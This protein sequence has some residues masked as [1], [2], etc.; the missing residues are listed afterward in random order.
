MRLGYVALTASATTMGYSLLIAVAMMDFTGEEVLT[1]CLAVGP[2][3]LGLGLGSVYGDHIPADKKISRLWLLEWLSVTVLPILPL[4]QLAAVF[5]FLQYTHPSVGLD[6]K[7]GL[8]FCLGIVGV[9]SFIAGILGGAQ[10]PLIL[11]SAQ[12]LSTEVALAFN[13]IGALLAGAGIVFLIALNIPFGHQILI[14][15]IIQLSGL[16]LLLSTFRKRTTGL[17][18]MFIPLIILFGTAHLYP[19]VEHY[20]VKNSYHRTRVDHVSQLFR[21][22]LYQVIKE[23]GELERVRTPYQTIDLFIE[24]PVPHLSIPGN[25]TLYLNRKPQIDILTTAIYH[26]SMVAAALNLFQGMPK[27]ILILGGGDGL[28]L[29]ELKH[30]TSTRITQIELDPLMLQFARDNNVISGLNENILSNM[31]KNM[32]VKIEDAISYLRKNSKEQFDVVIIDLPF[33]NGP[34][35]SRLYSLE[36]YKMVRRV[37]SPGAIVV[38]DLPLYFTEE[39]A[40][41]QESKT[42]LKTLRSAGFRYPLPFGPLASFVAVG[43]NETPLRFDYLRFPEE[44]SVSAASNLV[45]VF[46]DENLTE[47]DWAKQNVNTMF[48]PKEL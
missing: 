47:A 19:V 32:E 36:F 3:L 1:Q 37:L 31:P 44:L 26:E 23:F 15:G 41:A 7:T 17:A 27:K 21:K 12:K 14:F 2:Y 39:R 22:N 46:P 45:D 18:L 11:S 9:L 5:I 4:I 13:Y 28:L 33:P 38:I 10:L 42:I 48:W 35:L 8:A 20:T 29:K 30:L 40:F 25:A 16:M 43:M 6:Q 34:D 24:P